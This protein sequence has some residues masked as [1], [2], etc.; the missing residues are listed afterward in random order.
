MNKKP[1][2]AYTSN[3]IETTDERGYKQFDLTETYFNTIRLH[4]MK[5]IST[6]RVAVLLLFCLLLLKIN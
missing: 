3:N 5:S 6:D 2:H 1:R 4:E